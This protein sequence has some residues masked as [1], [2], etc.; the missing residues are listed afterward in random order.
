[1]RQ[2]IVKDLRSKT[3]AKDFIK[4]PR[5]ASRPALA[6]RTSSLP[7]CLDWWA[8]TVSERERMQAIILKV[9]SSHNSFSSHNCSIVYDVNLRRFTHA[10]PCLC[11]T[12]VTR[13]ASVVSYSITMIPSLIIQV[14]CT[15]KFNFLCNAILRC[16][17]TNR[18]RNHAHVC[19]RSPFVVYVIIEVLWK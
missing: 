18:T 17:S 7:I 8:V 2:P 16:R 14:R 5:G 4:C 1:M 11:A 12:Y 19:F 15:N 13:R 3:K 10:T 9:A 6:S